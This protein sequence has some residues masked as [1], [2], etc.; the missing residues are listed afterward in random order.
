M[1]PLA[2]VFLL[3]IVAG[4]RV[5]TPLAAVFLVRGGIAGIVL[6]VAAIAEYV[7]DL[8]PQMGPRTAPP[9]LVAR[10]VSAG[11]IG[12]MIAGPTGYFAIALAVIGALIGAYGG[13]AV[14]MWAIGK[15]GPIAAGLSESAVAILIAAYVVLHL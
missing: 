5:F 3:G 14:R 12:Y 4:L 9:A 6:A 15:I 8:L 11:F 1:H 10:V 13:K 7:G 2:G